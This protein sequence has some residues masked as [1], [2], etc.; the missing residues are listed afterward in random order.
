MNHFNNNI[1]T[2]YNQNLSLPLRVRVSKVRF[3]RLS[4]R[5]KNRWWKKS[6][7][8]TNLFSLLN[9]V[10]FAINWLMLLPKHFRKI[11][12]TIDWPKNWQQ[13]WQFSI[14]SSLFPSLSQPKKSL[15]VFWMPLISMIYTYC[16]CWATPELLLG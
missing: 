6:R 1:K 16:L 7:S 2:D 9:M 3:L 15:K 8:A 13:F 14:K 12:F 4:K 11:S 5:Q 10:V